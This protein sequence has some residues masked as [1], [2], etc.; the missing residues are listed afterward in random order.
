M[1]LYDKIIAAYPELADNSAA[2]MDG[3]IFLRN[4]ADGSGDYIQTWNYSK[5]LTKELQ[6]YLRK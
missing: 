2:F 3:T 4:D 5:A 1:T 6:Q